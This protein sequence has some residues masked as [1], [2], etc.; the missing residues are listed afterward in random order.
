RGPWER[1]FVDAAR[2]SPGALPAP[3]APTVLCMRAGIGSSHRAVVGARPAAWLPSASILPP[4]RLGVFRE[5]ARFLSP[6]SILI[7][8]WSDGSSCATQWCRS[9]ARSLGL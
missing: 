1:A 7:L 4:L 5:R 2:W 8:T 3:Q 6:H 9:T